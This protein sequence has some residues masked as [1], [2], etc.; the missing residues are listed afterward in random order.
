MVTRAVMI[1]AQVY[2]DPIWAQLIADTLP[3][4]AFASAWTLLV[5]FFVKLVGVALGSGT[6]ATPGTVIQIT[7]YGAYLWLIVTY[8]FNDVAAVL[9]YALLC[10][11]YAALLGTGLY[12]CPRLLALLH[13]TLARHPALAVRLAACSGASLLV[14]AAR[15]FGFAR[16]VVSPPHTASWWWQYGAL[17]LAPSFLFLVSMH[18]N[19]AISGGAAAAGA[20]S[21]S[22]RSG[23]SGSGG[24]GPG[25]TPP[26][27]GKN[28]SGKSLN[29]LSDSSLKGRMGGPSTSRTVETAPLLKPI[30][31]YGSNVGDPQPH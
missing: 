27:G 11:I 2:S 5:A 22:S 26:L 29:S 30:S 7:A 17:E 4:M 18:P 23:A 24:G 13:P 15:T 21:S 1:P 19:A 8:F 25:G 28:H 6:S 3:V 9:L 12:F 14:F 10:C 31:S 20:N 16:K